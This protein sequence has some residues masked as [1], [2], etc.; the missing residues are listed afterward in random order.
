MLLPVQHWIFGWQVVSVGKH[1][2]GDV[3]EVHVT[4]RLLEVWSGNDLVK[5]VV[6]TSKGAIRKKRAGRPAQS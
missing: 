1:R 5:T 2:G 4:D 3:V 6:R